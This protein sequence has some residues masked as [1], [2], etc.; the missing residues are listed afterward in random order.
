MPYLVAGA[1]AAALALA[2]AFPF[3]AG[4]GVWG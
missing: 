2:V 4:M 3:L 1:I